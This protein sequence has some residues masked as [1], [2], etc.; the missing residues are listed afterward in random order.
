MGFEMIVAI[1]IIFFGI[2]LQGIFGFG[3]ALLAMPLLS[4]VMDLKIVTP[5]FAL[6][7]A[8]AT[9]VIFLMSWRSVKFSAIW[10]LLLATIPG[11]F[12][13][14]WLLKFIPQFLILKGIGLFLIAFGIYSLGK[15]KLP[16]ISDR[17][18][19]GF[20]IIA[21]ILGGAYNLNGP[22]VAVYGNLCRWNPLQFRA[23][24]QCY[25]CLSSTSILIGHAVNGLWTK[26]VFQLY[27]WGLPALAI[28]IWLG[29]EINRRLPVQRFQ[30]SIYF[31]LIGLGVLLW[32]VN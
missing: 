20:G 9:A 14:I 28:A 5:A 29:R 22:P 25:F 24:L 16:Q 23:T 13:G 11:V 10:R 26:Q 30:Q 3:S 12:C 8:T 15:F 2:L 7:M 18:A 21:G 27:G 1:A 4:L 31:L 32:V 19:Y 6:L 17:W